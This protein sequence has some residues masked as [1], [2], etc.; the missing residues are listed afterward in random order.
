MSGSKPRRILIIANRT[1]GSATLLAELRA[2]IAAGPCELV[3]LAPAFDASASWTRTEGQARAE[4]RQRIEAA[5][6]GMLELGAPVR[7]TI[8]DLD[9]LRAIQDLLVVEGEDF[10]EIIVST[11]PAPLSGW[12]KMDLA[13]RIG[14]RFGIPVTHVAAEG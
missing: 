13:T 9:P 12:L 5:C 1:A 3:L 2:R 10:D 6:A 8:G 7:S 14:R 4:L 11:L